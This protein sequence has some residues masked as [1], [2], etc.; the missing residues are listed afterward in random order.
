MKKVKIEI[1]IQ[2]DEGKGVESIRWKSDD[3]PSN[4]Q[5]SEAKGFFL[6]LFDNETL[7]TLKIDLWTQKMEIGEMDRLTYYTLKSMADTYYNATKNSDTASDLARFCQY[8]GEETGI[9]KP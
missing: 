9:L 3:P 8:F 5:F 6:S 7:E 4:G 2:I 1:E